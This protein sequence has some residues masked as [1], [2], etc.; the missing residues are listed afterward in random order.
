MVNFCVSLTTIPSRIREV[1]LTIDSLINQTKKPE[2]IFLNIP[3]KYERFPEQV[4]STEYLEKLRNLKNLEIT[5]CEDF[6][7]GTKLLGSINNLEKY[8]HVVLVDDD[9]V[10]QKDMFEIFFNEA[11]KKPDNAYS[12]CVYEIE[13]LKVGQGADGF[14]INTNYLKKII[15]FFNNYVKKNKSLFFNDDLWISIYLNKFLNVEI[16]SL[17]KFLKKRFFSGNKSIYKKHTTIDALIEL[18]EKDRKKARNLRHQESFLEYNMLK[19]IT[20]NFSNIKF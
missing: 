20:N 19:K 15:L 18:Y 3:Y 8:S 7:P 13:D 11:L 4:I 5:R 16:E 2:K 14:M 9:H 12:F 10:Y 17:N 1:S 6:G